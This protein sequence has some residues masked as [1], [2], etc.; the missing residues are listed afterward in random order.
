MADISGES[1]ETTHKKFEKQYPLDL[2][3]NPQEY[4]ANAKLARIIILKHPFTY[5]KVAFRGFV[6]MLLGVSR[7]PTYQLLGFDRIERVDSFAKLLIVVIEFFILAL[8][9]LGC[10][11]GVFC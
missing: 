9:Y 6:W 8:I 3:N 1:Y 7:A 11:Y 2:I 10:V 5:A 4:K